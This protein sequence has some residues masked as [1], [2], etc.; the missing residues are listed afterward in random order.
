MY[1]IKYGNELD[2]VFI[3]TILDIDASV[4]PESLRGTFKEVYNRFKANND[5]FIL[6][7]DDDKIIGYLCLF[8]IKDILYNK[9][10]NEDKLFDSD[11]SG[12]YLEQYIPY[13]TYKL[14]IISVVILPEYQ[15]Q[16]LSKY[17]KNG[18]YNYIFNKKKNNI[19]FSKTLSTS[20]SLAGKRFFKKMKFRVKKSLSEGYDLC[21]LI[22]N[23][24]FYKY[25]KG[26][27]K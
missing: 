26:V 2:S 19:L 27:C 12:E 23:Y 4:Y 14:Y 15:N 25:L 5:I 21:E 16:G 3:N 20:V 13:N 18:F 8:P 10:L 6:L 9:I 11:I 1:K 7:Y 17:L 24:K 22:M